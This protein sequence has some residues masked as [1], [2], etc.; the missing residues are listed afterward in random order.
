MPAVACSVAAGEL[1]LCWEYPNIAMH[2]NT[3]RGFYEALSKPLFYSDLSRAQKKRPGKV[4][5]PLVLSRSQ[6]AF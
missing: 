2:K 1:H 6:W 3:L 4:P 5:W